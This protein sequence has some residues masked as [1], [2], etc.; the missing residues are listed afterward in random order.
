L[1]GSR[2]WCLSCLS[3][4]LAFMAALRWGPR[5]KLCLHLYFPGLLP[6]TPSPPSNPNHGV[7][8]SGQAGRQALQPVRILAI[9]VRILAIPVRIL[10]IPVRILA[11]PV[12][13]MTSLVRTRGVGFMDVLNDVAI[14]PC[15]PSAHNQLYLYVELYCRQAHQHS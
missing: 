1:P 4:Y 13:I 14:F 6:G 8:C 5:W 15:A 11:S 10:A 12:R 3:P 2:R 7:G 9:P